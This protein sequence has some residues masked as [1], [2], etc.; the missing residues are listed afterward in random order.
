MASGKAGKQAAFYPGALWMGYF[1]PAMATLL[2]PLAYT[3]PA[4]ASTSCFQDLAETRN[5]TLGMPRHLVIEPDGKHA[6]YLR[7]GP[8]DT[9][10]RLY[11]FDADTKQ[12]REL[13]KPDAAPELLS[14]EEKA[15]RERARMT[16]SGITDFS[17]SEDGHMLLAT[18]G[19]TL[20]KIS[21][22][23]GA[24]SQVPGNG[25]IAP[26]LS[27]D[28]H[29]VAVVENSDL[30]VIDLAT[31]TD[32]ALTKGATDTL[33]RGLAEFAA[34][35]ELDRA[36][37]AWWSPDSRSLVYEEADTSGVEKHFITD[38]GHP[39]QAPSMFHYPRAGT[40]NARVRLG[41]IQRAG[42]ATIWI[43]WD[44]SAFP[45]VARVIWPK[46]GRLSIV[47]LNREQTVEKILSVDPA[48]GKTADLLTETDPAWLNL[49][50][51]FAPNFHSLDLPSWLPDGSGFLWA[52]ERNSVWQLELHHADGT[53]DQVVTP[54][55]FRVDALDGIDASGTGSVVV[56]AS[57]DR[58]SFGLYRVPL[59]GGAPQPLAAQ[60]GLHDAV[61]AS[62]HPGIFADS[63]S[64][65]D[66][67]AGVALR[68]E[69]GSLAAM[70]PS[71]AQTPANLPNV[72]YLTAGSGHFDTSVIRPH[73]FVAGRKYPVILSVYAGPGVKNVVHAPRGGLEDQCLADHG[74]IVVTLD[75]RGTPGRDHD[76]ERATKGDLI[77][78][79]LDDQVDGLQALG[80]QFPEMDMRHVGVE[81]W[82]FGGYFTAMATIRRPD[83]FSAGVAGAPVV[84]YQDY[85]TAYT[86]RYLGIP[87]HAPEAYRLS[88]VLTYA[89]QLQQPLL[90]IHGLTDDN[91]YFENTFKLTQ[92]LL[93]DGLRYNLMLLPGTHQLPDPVLRA[94]VD[95]ARAAFLKE[96]LTA[97]K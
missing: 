2:A 20:L 77:D 47:V 24:V 38:P 23:D 71:Q 85:D 95:E 87:Q 40:D 93:K 13:A 89:G 6:L 57:P 33:T 19:E 72:Q 75:G 17:L 97:D 64:L 1:L 34:A 50:P 15:R 48:T 54:P 32:T 91:V 43:G 14:T 80:Q 37:G 63:F 65:A 22:P 61:F 74:F 79:P 96:H 11:E 4:H 82:S 25:L 10:L 18:Q 12:E 41:I 76:F 58:T 78:A 55:G 29:S 16:L 70:L 42:S 62:G 66:G 36:D 28:G 56:T 81:G 26:R 30:H 5:D 46:A 73:D 49:R 39:E 59:H 68:H 92:A 84:D 88:N 9:K 44:Q 7:S 8:R 90:I 69:D 21:L 53:L 45:Y 31:G 83:V 52:A 3:P 86:E 51:M 60:P 35:E 67:S 27:P 94:R